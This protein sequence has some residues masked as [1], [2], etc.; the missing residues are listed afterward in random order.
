MKH[1]IFL[2]GG[3]SFTFEGDCIASVI[4]MN[5]DDSIRRC[6]KLYRR[7]VGYVAQRIDNPDTIDVRY[8]GCEC[9]AEADVYDF[10]GNEPL[11]NYLYGAVQLEVP[12]LRSLI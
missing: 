5:H 7:S 12:G 10:F 3:K 8:W 2:N 4:A 6:F 1:Q 9:R 11:A